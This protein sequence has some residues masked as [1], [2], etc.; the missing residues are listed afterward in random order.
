M[1]DNETI[2]HLPVACC[3]VWG[4][5][6]LVRW[7]TSGRLS[8]IFFAGLILGCIPT[9]RY[10]DS[11]VAIGVIA[12]LVAHFNRFPRIYRHYLAV[13]T[14]AIIPVDGGWTAV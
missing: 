9:M 6:L 2:A 14:G 12:F 7:S 11:V 13:F 10:A 5:Y 4:A 3:L 8:T 1:A